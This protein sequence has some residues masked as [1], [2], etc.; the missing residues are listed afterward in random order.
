MANTEDDKNLCELR[1]GDVL[2]GQ[3]LEYFGISPAKG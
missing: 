3:I 2:I 1:K